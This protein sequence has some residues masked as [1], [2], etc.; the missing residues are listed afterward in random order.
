V[1]RLTNVGLSVLA[2]LAGALALASDQVAEPV[3]RTAGNLPSFAE[4]AA[5]SERQV[6]DRGA[7]GLANVDIYRRDLEDR[8]AYLAWQRQFARDSWRW[9]LFST[10]LLMFVVLVIVGFGLAITYL[11]FTR[12]LPRARGR[13]D[14]PGVSEVASSEAPQGTVKIGPGGLEVTS[15]VIGLLVLALSLGFFYLYVTSVYPMQEARLQEHAEAAEAPSAPPV[16]NE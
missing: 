14:S 7:T 9:H 1:S 2:A 11:Q 12:E 16:P 5:E 13:A 4:I 8:A 6:H 3:E 15:Q 10:R